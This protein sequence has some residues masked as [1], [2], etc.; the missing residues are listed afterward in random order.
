MKE[1]RYHSDL[2]TTNCGEE[3]PLGLSYLAAFVEYKK[4]F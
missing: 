4:K 3:I 1:N 2:S